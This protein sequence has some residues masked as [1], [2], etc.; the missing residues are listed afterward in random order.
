MQSFNHVKAIRKS[1]PSDYI[2]K[3]LMMI[4][5]RRL[6]RTG[7]ISEKLGG[8]FLDI[9]NK[10]VRNNAKFRNYPDVDDFVGFALE[11][12]VRQAKKFDVHHPAANPLS[13]FTRVCYYAVIYRVKNYYKHIEFQNKLYQIVN[14]EF[15]QNSNIRHHHA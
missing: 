9:T 14:D 11:T 4:E 8:M 2:N 5:L 3:D 7:K 10:F 12:L 15:N 13:Y 1:K 6:K